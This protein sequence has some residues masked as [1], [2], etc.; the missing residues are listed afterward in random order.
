MSTF[1]CYDLFVGTKPVGRV[2]NA[3][4]AY[5]FFHNNLGSAVY[6]VYCDG[7][8]VLWLSR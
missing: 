4:D 5:A 2:D 6:R 1:L 7:T 8:R 3:S